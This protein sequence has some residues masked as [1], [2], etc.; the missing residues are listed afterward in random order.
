[1]QCRYC[2]RTEGNVA[3]IVCVSCGGDLE[4]IRVDRET[5]YDIILYDRDFLSAEHVPALMR[6]LPD[7]VA[8]FIRKIPVVVIP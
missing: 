2:G 3:R 5:F 7:Y 1:M 4:V 8:G 6:G